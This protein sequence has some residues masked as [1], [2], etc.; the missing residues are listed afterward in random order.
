MP[1][2]AECPDDH[3]RRVLLAVTGLSPQIVTETLYALAVKG[4][5][6]PTEIQIITTEP[7]AKNARLNLLSNEPGWFHQLRRDY[8]LPAIAFGEESIHIV[9]GPDGK[10]LGDIV[11]DADNVA[12]ADFITERVRTITADPS[13]SLHVS[14]AGGRKTM[15]FYV[16]YALSLFGRT[17]DRLSH[18]LVSSPFESL[19]D[20]FYPSPRT[21]V[22]HDRNGQALDARDARV[23]LGDIPF[24]RLRDGLPKDLLE[25]TATFSAA[26]AQAQIAL[27]P[28]EL[29]LDPAT[30]TIEAAGKRFDLPPQQFAL[31]WMLA[32]RCRA[33]Q[34]GV[35]WSD[36]G[37]AQE[38]L[39]YYGRLVG[40]N[41]GPYER[42]ERAYKRNFGKDNFEPHSAHIKRA[43]ERALGERR[44]SPYLI[45]KLDPIGGSRRHRFGLN[46]PPDA[47]RIVPAS[48]PV[49]Q[50][51]SKKAKIASSKPASARTAR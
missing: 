23:H 13:A 32:E 39:A 9:N 20:F 11:A 3:P 24:V 30:R 29:R 45:V 38:L 48:L 10:P 22:I 1:A 2:H 44:A 17:Q 31:Y 5:W 51:R 26:V 19:T 21:R 41:S 27:A 46:L 18:V 36:R 35:H 25:G 12:V 47:I 7:G 8:S 34:G 49:R 40:V 33:V 50:T 37:L 4:E 6:I 15:G 28:P 16:G 14:I 43:I 42:A